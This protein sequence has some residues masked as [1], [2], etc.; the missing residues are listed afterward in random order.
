MLGF[1]WA[2]IAGR[3]TEQKIVHLPAQSYEVVAADNPENP[4]FQ[5]VF[6]L[7]YEET[8]YNL[9][10]LPPKEKPALILYTQKQKN[11]DI[12]FAN[13]VI[14]RK[15]EPLTWK[16]RIRKMYNVLVFL[17]AVVLMP[18]SFCLWKNGFTG[19]KLLDGGFMIMLGYVF[20]FQFKGNKSLFM[21][22]AYYFGRFLEIIG[23]LGIFIIE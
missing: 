17:V 20:T 19:D 21:R 4:D 22:F 5:L 7:K 14:D 1:S 8:I 6:L 9:P 12:I 23:W 16:Q 18:I 13:F 2:M 15:G 11:E 10:S 3:K